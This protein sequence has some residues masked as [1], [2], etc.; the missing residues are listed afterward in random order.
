MRK[1]LM[2]GIQCS[3][4]PEKKFKTTQLCVRFRA[5]LTYENLNTRSL[6]AAVMGNSAK[7]YPTIQSLNER[8][9]D[10]YGASYQAS[11]T[12]QGQD[13]IVTFYFHF[14]NDRFLPGKTDVLG[15]IF[16]LLEEI[17]FHPAVENGAFDATILERERRNLLEYMQ[18]VMEDKQDY[19]ILRIQSLHFKELAQA[20]PFY[21]T[22][23]GISQVSGEELYQAYLSMLM[24]DAIEI[25]ISGDVDEEEIF[26]RLEQFPFTPREVEYW[27]PFYRQE[28]E[29]DILEEVETQ[30]LTQ[31][32][33]TLC[34]QHPFY[35]GTPD[36]EAFLVFNGL[37]GGY[38]HSK[39]FMNVRER[40]SLAYYASSHTDAYRGTLLVQAGINKKNK[41]F[42][43]DLIDQQQY[44]LQ[45]GD[46]SEEDLEKTKA[47][48]CNQYRASFDQ[49]RNLI[50]KESR[51]LRFLEVEDQDFEAKIQKV[52]REQVQEVAKKI[53]LETIYCLEG[54]D[55]E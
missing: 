24:N 41:E 25:I 21:G 11:S 18:M 29:E 36:Y 12:R 9:A 22:M 8:L 13:Q 30:R 27:S 42:V 2:S 28:Q 34:Y 53:T 6:L 45:Q 33:L 14:V 35:Y 54:V 39:L 51:R 47:L 50:E 17:L 16:T 15:T 10:E 40:E 49:P 5:P 19:A 20:A 44:L 37:F 55:D 23:E 38:P 31:S 26:A 48:L 46:F 32:K 43:L 1:E 7:N 4:L 52:T 3:I